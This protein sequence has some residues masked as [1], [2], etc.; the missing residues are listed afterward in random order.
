VGERRIMTDV[1]NLNSDVVEGENIA[2]IIIECPMCHDT[3]HH[4]DDSRDKYFW[5][6]T[7]HLVVKHTIHEITNYIIKS[8]EKEGLINN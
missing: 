4:S 6:F 5:S 1:N 7:F 8:A 2:N 3:Y